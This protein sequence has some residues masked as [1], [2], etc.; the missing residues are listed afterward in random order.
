MNAKV[1]I[2]ASKPVSPTT[3]RMKMIEIPSVQRKESITLASSSSGAV[4]AFYEGIRCATGEMRV[5][6]RHNPDTGW[7]PLK[8]GQ[9]RS[10]HDQP[11]R[12]SLEIAR[13]GVCRGQ[14]P[15]ASAT[16][17][18]RDLARGADRRFDTN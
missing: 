10:L 1:G 4:N 14:A 9:W 17:I 11:S 12:H 2:E 13:T 18:V 6:A 5:Y 8:D 16:Q 7:V 15:N 3:K